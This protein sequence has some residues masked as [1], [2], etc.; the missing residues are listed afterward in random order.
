MEGFGSFWHWLEAE[1][2]RVLLCVLHIFL[3]YLKGFVDE[4]FFPLV[5]DDAPFLIGIALTT[6]LQPCPVHAPISPMGTGHTEMYDS[7]GFGQFHLYGEQIV[8]TR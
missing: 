3:T 6:T 4:H 7:G 8:G 2:D 1:D 5:R